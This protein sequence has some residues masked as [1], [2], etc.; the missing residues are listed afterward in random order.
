MDIVQYLQAV[1]PH[2]ILALRRSRAHPVDALTPDRRAELVEILSG[3]AE[4]ASP[5]DHSH[6]KGFA[7][8]RSAAL[9]ALTEAV[10]IMAFCPGGV[11]PFELHFEAEWVGPSA[12]PCIGDRV[13]YSSA[14]LRSTGQVTGDA[15]FRRGVITAAVPS[16][17]ELPIV[18]VVWDGEPATHACSS[19]I[20]SGKT[21]DWRYSPVDGGAQAG[22]EVYHLQLG[23]K[24]TDGDVVRD[25]R[26][27]EYTI[28]AS[29][30]SRRKTLAI[31]VT[32]DECGGSGQ[33]PHRV[34]VNNLELEKPVDAVGEWEAWEERSV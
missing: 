14:F 4:I 25:R 27:V 32:C 17:G 12:P 9:D 13:R 22:D 24:V 1:I 8:K 23:W 10:A 7:G 20:G 3:S 18:C 11:R 31:E 33:R 15:P 28:D 26:G 30:P 16:L 21:L 6:R 34:N 29:M 19:C 2:R 5:A